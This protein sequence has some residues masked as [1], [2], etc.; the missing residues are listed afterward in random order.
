MNVV[1]VFTSQPLQTM[2]DNGGSGNWAANRKRLEKCT[3]LVATK[4]NTLREHFP[5]DRNV[6]QGAAFL[7]GKISN[8]AESSHHEGRLVIQLSEFKEINLPKV[9]TGN[10]NPVAYTSTEKL[11][12]EHGL[13]LSNLDWSDFPATNITPVSNVKALTIDEAKEG[14]A[15]T[16]G[17][18]TSCI[19][20]SITA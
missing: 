20:I 1:M 12:E 4:S 5:S 13:D 18:D 6:K 10:R 7:V 2:I 14:I 17:V 11:Q 8:I 16:L 15:K 19:E 3:Y 9:W